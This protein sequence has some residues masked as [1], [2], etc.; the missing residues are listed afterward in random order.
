MMNLG[1]YRKC[2]DL[3]YEQFLAQNNVRASQIEED[4]SYEKVTGVARVELGNG[5][6]FFFKDGKLK[7]IYTSD[8]V[9]AS[10][11]WNE[12]LANADNTPEQVARSRAGK[13]SNQLIF[14]GHGITASTT[15]GEVDFIEIYAPCSLQNYLENIYRDVPKFIR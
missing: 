1:D 13:T 3:S 2:F 5:Q 12:F 15:R 7:V 14:A 10:K 9:V 6:F 8:E 11:L 4:V